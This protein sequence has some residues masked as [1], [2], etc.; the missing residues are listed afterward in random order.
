MIECVFK[1]A[2]FRYDRQEGSHR[3]YIKEGVPRTI[4]I[5][6]YSS[7]DPDIILGNMRSA[8]MSRQDYFHFVKECKKSA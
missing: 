7:I 6:T 2:G 3:A 1:K 4:I 5:P 8:H